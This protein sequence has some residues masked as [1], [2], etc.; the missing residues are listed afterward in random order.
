MIQFYGVNNANRSIQFNNYV[1]DVDILFSHVR[2]YWSKDNPDAT[3]F[4]PRWKT[5][6]ENVGNYFIYDASYIR[7]RTIEIGYSLSDIP[8]VK[9]AGFSNLR[10]YLNGNNLFFWSK[11]PDD[12]E[13]TYSGG[14]ATEGAYPTVKR[15]NLGIEVTF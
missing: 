15:I 1:N 14:S 13:Q 10:L 3:S 5:L 4:L 8:V 12:R 2:D 6:A 7:L 9:K 11:L